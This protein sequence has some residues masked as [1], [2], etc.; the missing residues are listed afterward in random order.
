MTE[1]QIFQLILT[2][3]SSVVLFL[4]VKTLLD[5]VKDLTAEVKRLNSVLIDRIPT[6][7]EHMSTDQ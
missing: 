2:G 5:Q 4:W 1:V 6:L 3:G 7:S